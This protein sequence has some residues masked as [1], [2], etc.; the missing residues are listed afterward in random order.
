[1]ALE[2]A[3]SDLSD[4]GDTLEDSPDS[5]DFA[6]PATQLLSP[7]RPMPLAHSVDRVVKHIRISNCPVSPAKSPPEPQLT[8][9]PHPLSRTQRKNLKNRQKH[10]ARL[11]AE[12]HLPDPHARQ[13]RHKSSPIVASDL[14]V[15]TD[16][17]P[18]NG[19]YTGK[20]NEAFNDRSVPYCLSDLLERGF[21]HIKWDGW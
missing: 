13:E 5:S 21:R 20:K 1:M 18:T 10:A 17:P 16:R 3:N 9:P 2:N 15:E 8:P 4:L 11:K 12:G 19:A 14:N 7:K 6:T